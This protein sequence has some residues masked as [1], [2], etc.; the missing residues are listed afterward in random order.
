[1]DPW[2]Q[3]VYLEADG[4]KTIHDFVYQMAAKYGR[5]EPIPHELDKTIL[6]VMDSLLSDKLVELLD[7]KKELPERLKKPLSQLKRE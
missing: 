2:V 7:S 6:D 1:M 4:Q 3:L 5:G